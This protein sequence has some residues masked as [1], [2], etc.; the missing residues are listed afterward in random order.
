MNE[1]EQYINDEIM[2]SMEDKTRRME[3]VAW[4]EKPSGK[5]EGLEAYFS[6]FSHHNE[7][8]DQGAREGFFIGLTIAT[9]LWLGVIGVGLL[10]IF[11]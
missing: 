6:N 7:A 11:G 8:Y 4:G 9:F 1:F 10:I 3:D 2:K 5:P